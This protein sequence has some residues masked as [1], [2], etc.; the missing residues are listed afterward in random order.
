MKLQR[1]SCNSVRD[2]LSSDDILCDILLRLPPESVFKFIIV[3]KRWLKCICSYVFR[4]SYL[5][6]WKVSSR[7]L[8]FVVCN[9]L[10]LGRRPGGL[11]RTPSEPALPFLSTCQE[12]DDLKYSGILKRLGYF[13]DSS[14]GL[15]LCGRH[16]KTY[17][18]WDPVTKQQHKLPRPRV[19]FEELCMAFIA[20]DSPDDSICYKVIRAKCECKLNEVSTVT[21]ETFCS[22]TTTWYYSILTCTSTL[23]LCPWTV[24]TV[25]RGVVHW[26]AMRGNIAIYDQKQEE[27]HIAVVQLPGSYDFDEQILGESS[28][29]LLQYGISCKSGMEIWVLEKEIDNHTSLYSSNAHFKTR[30][31]L[32]YRLNFK[33]M[34]KKN[35]S[36]MTAYRTCSKS[37]ETQILSFL[38]QNSESVYIRSGDNIFLCHL[39][40]KEVE[41]V[42]YDGRGSSILW[43][44][45]KVVP[46]FKPAWPH[47]SF[48]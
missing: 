46:Y 36:V 32:R 20:E 23:S 40:S 41:V 35:P 42:Q 2:A 14:S 33:T 45:S 10:Y 29:G 37:K 28:D 9:S 15:L 6:R 48:L 39:Q 8:G 47:S 12:G 16:P 24:A 4:H 44:F 25:I 17:Y 11:R 13:I 5:R 26:F 31:T 22:K 38:S 1:M 21:I 18:V 7:L 30:W 43:D 34:W 19:Y 3:S 27:R